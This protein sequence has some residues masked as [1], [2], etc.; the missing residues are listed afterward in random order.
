MKLKLPNFSGSWKKPASASASQN[1]AVPSPAPVVAAPSAMPVS[2]AAPAALKPSAKPQQKQLFVKL[3]AGVALIAAALGAACLF[4]EQTVKDFTVYMDGPGSVVHLKDL[5]LIP[6]NEGK[7][8]WF[9]GEMVL[10]QALV[11]RELGVAVETPAMR[12]SVTMLQWLEKEEEVEQQGSDGKP[13]KKKAYSYYP[14]WSDKYY[15]PFDFH[16]IDEAH[17]NPAMVFKAKEWKADM[18]NVGPFEVPAA[19]I[20][21]FVP[22]EVPKELKEKFPPEWRPLVKFKDGQFY[23]GP[24]EPDLP[25][26]GDTLIRYE[27]A[28]P[29]QKVSVIGMQS[30]PRI[31][32]F[33]TKYHG[34][35]LKTQTGFVSDATAFFKPMH[36]GFSWWVWAIRAAW[37]LG[38]GVGV[39]LVVWNVNLLLPKSFSRIFKQ[40][41]VAYATTGVALLLLYIYWQSPLV[42]WW[43][44]WL[45]IPAVILIDLIYQLV[46]YA[47]L[48]ERKGWKQLIR[49]RVKEKPLP[50]AGTALASD[51]I[52]PVQPSI[53]PLPN[54]P[55]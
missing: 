18:V 35:I 29:H 38:L 45:V 33:I 9:S 21:N 42:K 6:E 27:V 51:V 31:V 3:A 20:K 50:A 7:P 25:Q 17:Q 26:V 10:R 39:Y 23:I 12:R 54:N 2:P 34:D 11:D 47:K 46:K 13:I 22:Y 44:A 32:P 4:E 8:V 55:S 14:D 28:A 24:G 30:G 37:I 48:R 41:A 1:P 49:K 15:G 5:Q 36:S 16:V 43:W 19:E 40:R 52:P 53:N